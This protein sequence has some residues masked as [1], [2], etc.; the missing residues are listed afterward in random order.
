MKVAKR[1]TSVGLTLLMAFSLAACSST[2]Q[3]ASTD[4]TP[5]QPSTPTAPK[6]EPAQPTAEKIKLVYARGKDATDSTKKLVEAFQKAHPNIEVEIREMPA[7]SGQSHDQYVTMF[8]AQSSEIDVFDLDVIWPAEFAQAGYL[9]PLDRLME[10]DGIETG[11]Y[12]KGAMDAGNFGGQQWTMPKFIDA[13]LLFYRKD[14][15]SEAPKTWDDLIAQAKATK[16]KGGTKFGYLMQAK[17]YEGLVCNFVEF[18]ASYGGKILDEQGKVAVNNPA[19]IKGLKKMIEVVKSDFVPTNIT[20]F[21]E[22]ESHTAFLEGQAPFIRNWPYQ[23]ALAQDQ[24]QSKIVDQVG[25]APL[26]AGDAG[27]AAALG[28][29]MGGINK[30]SKHPKEA[31]EFLKFMTGPEGQKISAV[32]G[33]LA[34][35]Y[36]PAYEDADVQKASPL[37]ANKDFV[38]GVSAAVS[39]PTTP[40]YPK[41]SE[42]IQIEVSKAL[43]GQQTAEQAVQSMETQMNDLMKK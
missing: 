40:I 16:G 21:M 29:W 22:P 13:G 43:A 36:L 19:T 14:L 28:G 11:K 5:S 18:S 24:A 1:L 42:V 26:P 20:T 37:F 34:P 15:V 25:I 35:T 39:R 31:W 27:S 32:E 10:Q 41:I 23:F 7:D 2:S 33:G 3:Q 38:D 9:L 12:I 8:S 4:T 6:T 17:Q 30:F